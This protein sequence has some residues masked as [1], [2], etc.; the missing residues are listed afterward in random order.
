MTT[1]VMH[2]AFLYRLGEVPRYERFPLPV[3]GED[4]VV[5]TVEAAALKPSDRL[6]ARGVGYAPAVLPHVVGLDGVGRLGDGSRV[7][8]MISQPPYGGMAE[9]TLVRRG[10]WL[11]VPD[12]VDDVTAAAIANPGMAAWKT[13]SWEGRVEEGHRV[14]ILGAT[15]MSGRIA[16]QLAIDR[17][18]WVVAAGRDKRVLD[19]LVE[20][21]AAAT[22][23]TT[24]PSERTS[25]A[26]RRRWPRRRSRA[27]GRGRRCWR[28]GG[29][30]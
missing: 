21:G 30:R 2:A 26:V 19:L 15:G 6:M 13:I 7:V 5:V 27:V 8:F 24:R 20:W 9:Q 3:A 23:G 1:D 10:A 17:G 12:G 16:A 18:A 4:E 29:C 25:G 11:A 22:R 28:A 14:L